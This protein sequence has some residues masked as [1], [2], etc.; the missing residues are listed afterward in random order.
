MP[1]LDIPKL[2]V[3]R[4]LPLPPFAQVRDHL[5]E[6]ISDGRLDGRLPSER[7]LA[8]HFAVSYMTARRAI[9]DLVDEGMLAREQGRGT[10][11]RN[12]NSRAAA[13]GSIGIVLSPKIR[14]GVANPYVAA[15]LQGVAE[16]G[17]RLGYRR[18]IIAEHPLDLMRDGR[19]GSVSGIIAIALSAAGFDDLETARKVM[20]VVGIDCGKGTE[21]IPNI[22]CDN[23]GGTRLAVEHL[24]QLGH[25]RIGY[26]GGDPPGEVA[27]ARRD[28]YLDALRA[29]GL[30]ADPQYVVEGDFEMESGYAGAGRLLGQPQPPT[31]I[32]CANDAMA[33]GVYQRAHGSGLK[34]PHDLS[35]IGFDDLPA[36]GYITPGLSTIRAP[37]VELGWAA[38]QAL[39]RMVG[40]TPQA[41]HRV[42]PV[43][44][45]LRHSTAPPK[46]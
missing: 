13:I 6:L 23:R 10:F 15:I 26:I 7:D 21:E 41:S 46:A 43:S 14:Q 31:A 16:E 17:R 18:T 25:K 2:A 35:V 45:Y 34:I 24:I 28:G 1:Q 3:D 40:D 4:S 22:V 9:G 11:V 27:E 44:I 42:L 12:R 19:V 30:P 39:T 5:R 37:R 33:F 38:I 32:A 20:P 29:A 36:A 8:D